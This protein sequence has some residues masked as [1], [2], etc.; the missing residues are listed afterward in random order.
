[1]NALTDPA[2]SIRRRLLLT[3]FVP[4]ATV[5]LAGTISDYVTA[6]RPYTEALDQTLLDSAL[7]IAA[8]V[9]RDSTGHLRLALPSDVLTGLRVGSQ[10]ALYFKVRDAA[11]KLIAGDADL[12]DSDR[13]PYGSSGS[14]MRYGD[15]DVRLIEHRAYAGDEPITVA[16]AE[17]TRQRDALRERIVLS[18]VTTDVVVLGLILALIWFSV[19]MSLE[20]LAQIEHELS[21]RAPRDLTPLSGTSVPVEVRGLVAALNG[22]FSTVRDNAANQRKF[23]ESAAHQLRTPLAGIQAQ[24]E[25]MLTNEPDNTAGHERLRRVLEGVRRLSH[26]THE[27]LTLARA[28]EGA[29]HGLRLERVEL[30]S[31]AETALAENLGVAEHARIDLG[32]QLEPAHADGVDWLLAEA[33]K[34]L[35]DNA[36][37]HTPAGGAVT[38]RCGVTGGAP[39]LEVTDTGIGIPREE[40][41]RVAERFFRASN[42]RGAGSGLGLAIVSDVTLLHRGTLSID[43]GPHGVGTT[44]RIQLPRVATD[45][46]FAEPRVERPSGGVAP[47]TTAIG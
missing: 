25:V 46:P 39:Y 8:H 1:M 44:V 43:A 35:V 13:G 4:A 29:N 41:S 27:L 45:A 40:R 15:K 20:P 47:A 37:A 36:I 5:L 22:L 42:A 38:V 34:A 33:A 10:D 9:E 24:L 26:T 16:I 18:A 31:I 30:A 14:D 28:D 19:R 23:L 2:P 21:A 32:A 12:P 3:L 7:V 6:L 17:T 11:G